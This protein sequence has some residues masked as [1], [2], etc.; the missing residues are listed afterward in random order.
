MFSQP[1]RARYKHY[2]T[3]FRIGGGQNFL[4]LFLSLA[5]L[6]ERDWNTRAAMSK[7]LIQF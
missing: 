1:C 7:Y 4:F 5:F 3:R 6:S 2:C